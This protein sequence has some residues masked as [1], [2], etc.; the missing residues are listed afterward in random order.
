LKIAVL[1]AGITGLTLARVLDAD[2]HEVLVLEKGDRIGGLCQSSVIDGF[3]SDHS[4][5]HIVFSKDRPT[6][7]W[8]LDRIGRNNLVER[9][10]ESR[11]LWHDRYVQYPFE[12]GIGDLTPEAKFDCIKGYIEANRRRES[13]EPCPEN[14]RDW[15]LWKMGRGF[16][17]HF[18]IPYN[19]K[20][21]SCDLR[22]MASDWVAGR[23]PDAPL[24]D[25]LK[26]AV[27]IRTEGYAHQAIFYYPKHGGFQALVDGTADPIQESIRTNTPVV[28]VRRRGDGWRVNDED[29]DFVINTIPLPELAKVFEDLPESVADDCRALAPIS[30]INV[31]FGFEHDGELA[32]RSWIYLPFESQGPMNRVTFF[33]NYSPH[34]APPGH[35]SYMAEVT[36]R[37]R[38]DPDQAWLDDLARCMEEQGLLRRSD[39]VTT[40]WFRSP[41]AYIDQN[42]EFGPR[43]ERL[44]N[45][46]DESGMLTIGRFGR[47]EYHNSDQCIMRA[48]QAHTQL[49]SQA[50]TGIAKPFCFV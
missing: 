32:D 36:Y 21:W 3:T 6:L 39:I 30:L 15:I 25:I 27:G 49:R 8:M 11:I 50:K 46:F 9:R 20:I 5:G 29:F 18:M 16:A 19:E 13:G 17:D 4:G 31:L 22:E 28:S 47:Y 42:L 33:S 43:I 37:G 14:F 2:G 34:N 44:R 7:D 41:Y 35:A 45:W 48:R 40:H 10:R 23:V 12:N 26:A 1:G 38:L 24:D